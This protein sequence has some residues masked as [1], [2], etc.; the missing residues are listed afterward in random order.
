MVAFG[1]EQFRAKNV[2]PLHHQ[3]SL[4]RCV[5]SDA[6]KE[7]TRGI[8]RRLAKETPYTEE[9]ELV[10]HGSDHSMGVLLV[11]RAGKTGDWASYLEEFPERRQARCMG[12]V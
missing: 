4:D 9:L 8:I 11:R 2:G 12:K 7:K 1:V 5:L 3:K 6:E 10:K